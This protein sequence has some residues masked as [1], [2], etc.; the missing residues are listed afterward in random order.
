HNLQRFLAP[1]DHLE[2]VWYYVPVV[3]AGLL[4]GTLL[5][6]PFARWLLGNADAAR[7]RSPELGFALLA[8]GWCVLFFTLSG[9]KLPT[10][11]LP[12]FPF[13]ALALGTWWESTSPRATPPYPPRLGGGRGGWLGDL[14]FGIWLL[15]LAAVHYVALP[16]YAALRSPLGAPAA[17]LRAACSDPAVP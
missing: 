8:G 12:A 11:I 1:F 3:L 9:S 5:A 17:E 14:G 15:L 16:W 6:W 10:Y 2:P 7:G 4:P 13:L